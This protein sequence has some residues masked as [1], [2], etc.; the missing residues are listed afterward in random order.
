LSKNAAHV[1]MFYNVEVLSIQDTLH[2]IDLYLYNVGMGPVTV[3]KIC[4]GMRRQCPCEIL[5][6]GYEAQMIPIPVSDIVIQTNINCP[7]LRQS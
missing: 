3:L 1:G 5:C 7:I 2:F 6:F 4:L